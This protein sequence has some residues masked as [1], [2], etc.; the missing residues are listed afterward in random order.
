MS[1]SVVRRAV[2]RLDGREEE[3]TGAEAWRPPGPGWPP[4]RLT[5]RA[6]PWRMGVNDTVLRGIEQNNDASEPYCALSLGFFFL[7]LY[8][9]LF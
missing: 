9:W 5:G 7:K 2:S 3:R 4:V 1:N 6:A 8:L